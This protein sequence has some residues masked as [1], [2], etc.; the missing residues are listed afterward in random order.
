MCKNLWKFNVKI[1]FNYVF[2]VLFTSK[3]QVSVTTR[4]D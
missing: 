3:T 2:S 1:I 4:M